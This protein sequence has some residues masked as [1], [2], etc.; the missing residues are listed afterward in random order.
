MPLHHPRANVQSR[1]AKAGIERNIIHWSIHYLMSRGRTQSEACNSTGPPGA[2]R[3]SERVPR[4]PRK[5]LLTYTEYIPLLGLYVSTEMN[6]KDRYLSLSKARDI[7]KLSTF[8]S[9]SG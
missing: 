1:V 5:Y 7:L 9:V 6:E 3:P 8:H 2:G 4:I